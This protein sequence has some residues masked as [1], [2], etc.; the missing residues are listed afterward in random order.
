MKRLHIGAKLI[1]SLLPVLLAFFI[2]G[3][4]ILFVGEN[5]LQTY[6]LML[7]KSLFTL[8]GLGTTLHYASPMI[9]AGLAI[10]VTFKANIFNM[11]VDGQ[12]IFGGFFAGLVGTMLQ[13]ANP[14]L[15]KAVCFGVGALFGMLFAL[16]PALLRAY[17]HVDEMVVTLTLNYAMLK[18]LEYLSSGPFREHGSGYVCTPMIQESAMFTRLGNGRLTF[19]SV[20]SLVVFL[21][22]AFMM[23]KTTLGYSIEAIGKN[24]TFAEAT[25]LHTRRKVII[26][27]L[28]S[29]ALAG[30]SGAGHMMSEEFKYTL[31]F[32]G[33]P[34]LGWDG[35]LIALLGRHSPAGIL[36]AGIFYSA[37]KT[38]ADNIN[39]Y[40]SVP[41]EIVAV[42]QSLIIL[43]L[44]IRFVD[45]RF[46]LRQWIAKRF[47]GKKQVAEEQ[48]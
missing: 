48:V 40:T 4:V 20:I 29:G 41:K 9:L 26:L 16:L 5:P 31:T 27:M 25:G 37:L 24:P 14:F 42:V 46:Q 47:S 19:F 36:V 21:G 39:M 3:I 38:G 35:M 45:E 2:G 34:G 15:H 33:S 32:S 17:L 10:A 28:I 23:R 11:G 43:F 44:A 12:L 13:D 18:I 6:W 30:F 22:M 7:G 1:N 8:K